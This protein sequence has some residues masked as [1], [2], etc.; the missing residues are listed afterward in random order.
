M[1]GNEKE[2]IEEINSRIKYYNE[3]NHLNEY[4]KYIKKVL[5]S[6]Y[7]HNGNY[8][9]PEYN[10]AEMVIKELEKIIKESNY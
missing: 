10:G 1:L 3:T 4:K 6:E 8:S 7:Y 5:N 9:K 2:V